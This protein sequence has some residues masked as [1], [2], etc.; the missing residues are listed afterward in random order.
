MEDKKFN[1]EVDSMLCKACG[2]CAFQ[3]PKGVFSPSGQ[4]NPHGYEYMIADS[5]KGCIGCL[6]CIA[7]CPDF[8]I[9]V[10]PL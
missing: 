3:C 2:Y 5:E 6:K 1:V 4:I 8:A 10:T 9:T 7:I